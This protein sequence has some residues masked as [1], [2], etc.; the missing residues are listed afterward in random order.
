VQLTR[1]QGRLDG[2]QPVF[3][4]LAVGR[5]NI[6]KIALE[7]ELII[8]HE[9]LCPHQKLRRDLLQQRGLVLICHGTRGPIVNQY[10]PVDPLSMGDL[11]ELC[12]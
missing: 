12:D 5:Y 4:L 10:A 3:L 9:Q 11:K 6:R 8:L 7:E 1:L 2:Q